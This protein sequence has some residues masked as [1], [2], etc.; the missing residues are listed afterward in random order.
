M[1]YNE[2]PEEMF[3][4]NCLYPRVL[5][6]IIIFFVLVFLLEILSFKLQLVILGDSTFYLPVLPHC[7]C[8]WILPKQILENKSLSST[9]LNLLLTWDI[10][11][12]FNWS[13]TTLNMKIKWCSDSKSTLEPMYVNIWKYFFVLELTFLFWRDVL[14]H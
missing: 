2:D 1:L 3:K 7:S 4:V 8:T 14:V 5:M 9:K 13:W 10:A 12:T 11:L 6:I